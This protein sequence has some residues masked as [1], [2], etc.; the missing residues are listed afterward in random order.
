MTANKTF[1]EW[2]IIE[3]MGHRKLAGK[4]SEY[5]IGGAAFIRVD[6]PGSATQL[7]NPSAV[8]CITPTTEEI[9]RQVAANH[10]PEPVQ[11]WELPEPKELACNGKLDLAP[12]NADTEAWDA[13]N[14]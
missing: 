2:A 12:P 10:M 8:Y 14:E 9:A 13:Y 5:S 1:E 7:Y 6:I 11:R 3:L 4:V